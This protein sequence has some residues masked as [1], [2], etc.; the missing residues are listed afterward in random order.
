M[1]SC[2]DGRPFFSLFLFFFLIVTVLL[3]YTNF[4]FCWLSDIDLMKWAREHHIYKTQLLS[5]NIIDCF[6]IN[7]NYSFLFCLLVCLFVCSLL[8]TLSFS[9][10]CRHFFFSVFFV[11][12]KHTYIPSDMKRQMDENDRQLSVNKIMN[13]RRHI[14]AH[15]FVCV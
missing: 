10:D 3:F 7:L 8:E 12:I 15:L 5:F 14:Y 4:I 2:D 13:V 6:S 11:H 1:N 9:P